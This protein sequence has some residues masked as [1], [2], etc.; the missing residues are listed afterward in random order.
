MQYVVIIGDR[1]KIASVYTI[2]H[3]REH[4]RPPWVRFMKNTLAQLDLD[5]V[6]KLESSAQLSSLNT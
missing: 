1:L 4:D 6:S 2:N 3:F 5:G